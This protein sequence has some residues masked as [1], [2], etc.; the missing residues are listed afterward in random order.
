MKTSFKHLFRTPVKALLFFLLMTA[1]TVFLVL[2]AGLLVQTNARIAAAKQ[3][4]TTLGTVEQKPERTST[5]ALHNSCA[6]KIESAQVNSYS[7]II[8]VDVLNFEGANYVTPPESR[9]C[10]LAY[11]PDFH[12]SYGGSGVVN[13]VYV[14]E[15]TPVND[16]D[17]P[18][19]GEIQ[20]EKLLY[21]YAASHGMFLPEP[22]EGETISLCNHFTTDFSPLKAGKRYI[23]TVVLD[24]Y[25][26]LD[27]GKMEYVVY[28]GPF[29]S[30]ITAAGTRDEATKIPQVHALSSQE[31]GGYTYVNSGVRVCPEPGAPVYAEEV[32]P[33]F[34]ENGQKGQAWLAWVDQLEILSKEKSYF[35]VLSANSLEA[36]PA[37]HEKQVRVPQGR[38]ITKEEFD[39][40]AMVCMLPDDLFL[41]NRLEIGDKI[42][43]SLVLSQHSRWQPASCLCSAYA[44]TYSPLD[45][46]GKPYQPFWEREYEIVGTYSFLDNSMTN[47]SSEFSTEMF[48]IP[49]KSVKNSDE[50]HIVYESPMN[51]LT[52]SFQ[53]PN[54]CIEE[55]NEALRT[56]V[57][58]AERLVIAYDDNGYSDVVSSLNNAKTSAVLLVAVGLAAALCVIMLLL[59]FFIIRQKKRTA[60][61]RSLGMSRR[62]CRTSLVAGILVLTIAAAAAG[63]VGGAVL[64]ERV[65]PVSNR[66]ETTDTGGFDTAYSLWARAGNA[67]EEIN[68]DVSAP[69][70]AYLAAP[71]GQVILVLALALPLAERNLKVKPIVLLSAREE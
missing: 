34:Y 2:G 15:F 49:A 8:P 54:G 21:G 64:M 51:T 50:N 36:L 30:Q 18:D 23:A 11:L 22:K 38:A 16:I 7:D 35:N 66:E 44:G 65:Q 1:C 41:Q 33:E 45:A 6:E 31:A 71:L 17:S 13:D 48:L 59:Y 20:V 19:A 60:I 10:Y 56:A 5:I 28:T 24:Y 46:Q 47:G 26:G 57:P 12:S 62:Q 42:P 25:T 68:S 40:G 37:F 55:F 27:Q 58:E 14:L 29:S 3:E 53:I 63:S 32:T 52:T 43:L 69:I 9:V 4:F 70:A 61:E 39:S 67:G